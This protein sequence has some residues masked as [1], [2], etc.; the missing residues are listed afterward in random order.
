MIWMATAE[1]HVTQ[2]LAAA[3]RPAVVVATMMVYAIRDRERTDLFVLQTA[4]MRTLLAV[5]RI[6]MGR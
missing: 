1:I 3:A 2:V 6:R 4:A 5:R